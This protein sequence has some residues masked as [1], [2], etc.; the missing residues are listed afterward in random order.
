M[1][2]GY[3]ASVV[4][5]CASLAEHSSATS[6]QPPPTPPKSPVVMTVRCSITLLTPPGRA[7]I[8]T[9]RME[10]PGAVEAVGRHFIAAAGR[11]LDHTRTDQLRYGRIGSPPGEPVVVRVCGPEAVE[12]HCHGGRAAAAMIEAIFVAEGATPRDWR[13]WVRDRHGDRFAADAEI[14]LAEAPTERT[15][16][17]LLDQF[18]G[19]LR[20]EWEAVEGALAQ[21]DAGAAAA[22]IDRLRARA[23]LGRHLVRPWR[24]VLAGRPNVGKS[25]LINALVGYARAIVHPRAGTTRD[26]LH[27]AAAFEGWPVELCDTAGLG[28]ADGG[29]EASGMHR[30]RQ[31]L[32]EADLVLWILEAGDDQAPPPISGGVAARQVFNKADL[33]APPRRQAAEAPL[34]SALTGEGVERL[35]SHVAA[36]LVP[37]PPPLGAA[38]PFTDA[39]IAA[40][41]AAAEFLQ[42]DV[43]D[44]AVRVMRHAGTAH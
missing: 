37:E 24:V 38:V 21:G 34:V 14:A 4:G 25:S 30:A 3:D 35:A 7:A 29:L 8:A 12:I 15:A 5:D 6:H 1:R 22:R 42:R 16:A 40:L 10:G 28:T 17:I 11:P 23:P 20:R 19:A 2:F 18:H 36:W 26:L 32:A 43:I 33:L 31:A 44:D 41:D 39:Q 27:A 9:V 13:Q